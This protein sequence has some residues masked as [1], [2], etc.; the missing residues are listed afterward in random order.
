MSLSG[1]EYGETGG[2]NVVALK[3]LLGE[4]LAAFELSRGSRRAQHGSSLAVE[5]VD[6]ALNERR[7]GADYGQ[8]GVEGFGERGKL[9]RRKDVAR[10]AGGLHGDAGIARNAI[11]LFHRR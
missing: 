11:D 4:N 5:F 1:F 9:R 10:D 7:L 2:G 8:G 3:K 6:H